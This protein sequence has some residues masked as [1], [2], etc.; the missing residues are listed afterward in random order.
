MDVNKKI[1]SIIKIKKSASIADFIQALGF[2][3]AY[4]NR[5]LNNLINK[6]LIIR[7]GKTNKT[8]YVLY[9]KNNINFKKIYKIKNLNEDF[10]FG[11]I[12]LT[13]NFFNNL[14]DKVQ[15]IIYYAFTEMLNNAIDHSSSETVEIII[16]Q[17]KNNL[18]FEINDFGVG[19]FE[20]IKNK[21][22]LNNHL[23]A[24]QDLLKGKQT[25]DQQHHTGEGI[26]FTSKIVDKFI[27]T[28][29]NLKLII[30]NNINDIFVKENK[31]IKGTQV[32]WQIKKNTQKKLTDIFNKYADSDLS[33]NKTEVK[34]D[35]YKI[36]SPHISRSEAKRLIS[37]LEKFKTVI[38]D[39]KDVNLIGQGFAD[40]IFRVWQ[41]KYPQIKIKSINTNKIIK[42]MIGRVLNN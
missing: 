15:S 10:V 37:G 3:R 12:K 19:I 2:S 31:K 22:Q 34:V 39:F 42:M 32:S 14:P 41:N 11:E 16:D 29:S 38:L 5:I 23:E 30:N 25:T 28:S 36:N 7:Q 13:T 9:K 6:N 33:F 4:I 21:K 1:L 17:N 18:F 40:E 8:H 24:L 35:L 26:F 27:I 20:H